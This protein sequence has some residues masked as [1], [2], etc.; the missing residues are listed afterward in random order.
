MLIRSNKV[1]IK[2][3]NELEMEQSVYQDPVD[4]AIEPDI[5]Y[6]EFNDE[7]RDEGERGTKL[8]CEMEIERHLKILED[9]KVPDQLV[10]AKNLIKQLN[11]RSA[12]ARRKQT[13]ERIAMMRNVGNS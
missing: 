10:L 11:R 7:Y 12:A 1:A 2:E 4:A 8:T 3:G 5:L 13:E 6:T 9:F